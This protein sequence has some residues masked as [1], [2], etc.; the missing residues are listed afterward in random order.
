MFQKKIFLD[1]N[2]CKSQSTMEATKIPRCTLLTRI[3]GAILF[4]PSG[5]VLAFIGYILIFTITNQPENFLGTAFGIT[6]ALPVAAVLLIIFVIG[7][8]L[9]STKKVYK[10]RTCGF[11][12]NRDWLLLILPP[13]HHLVHITETR[14]HKLL[15]ILT[16]NDIYK[17]SHY[18]PNV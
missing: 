4:F 3:F 6:I 2:A 15:S 12:F 13:Q 18:C 17:H 11:I 14:K 1:C 16:A 8:F 5:I 7:G 10:C 9:L